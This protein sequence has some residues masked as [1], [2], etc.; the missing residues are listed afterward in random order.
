MKTLGAKADNLQKLSDA[1]FNVPKLYVV[2]GSKHL[3][4][5]R[6]IAEF[7]RWRAQNGVKAVA[8][9]SSS[10]QED[11]SENSFAGQF[12]TS[13]DVQTEEDFINALRKVAASKASK[14]YS[15]QDGIV[16]AIVQEFIEP[17]VAG[18][19]FSI[20]PATGNNEFVINAAS[21]RGTRVV[22]GKA[23]EQ[24]F[25]NRLDSDIS[26][27]GTTGSLTDDQIRELSD[28]TFKIESLFG[29]PQDIEWAIKDG[30]LYVL[31][32]RPITR[33]SHLRLWDS[34]NISESFPGIVL[35]LTYSI[36]KHGYMLVYKAQGYSAGLSWY[37]IEA[38]HRTFDAMIG[39]F[40]GRLYYN[41]L[42]W[43]KFI[44]IFPGSRANQQ[45]LDDQIATQ[46]QAIHQAPERQSLAFKSKFVSRALYRAVFFKK[47]LND[48]YVR[49]AKLENDIGHM[50][51]DGDSQILM[52]RYTHIEQTMVPHF[53][54]S[55][56]NDFFVMIYHGRLKKLLA[57]KES[58]NQANI[59]GA[60]NGVIS[61]EQATLLYELA[62]QFKKD[63]KAHD[64]LES[65]DYQALDNYLVGTELET[66]IKKYIEIF[67]HR[68][69]GDQKIEVKNPTLEPHGI[70]KLMKA[71]TQLD[72]S[73]VHERLSGTQAAA[74][75][76]EKSIES[77]LGLI[78]RLIYKFLLNRLKHHLRIREK[79]RLIRG[80]VYGYMRDLFPKVGEALVEEG[81]IK[82]AQDIFYL[83]IEEI[84]QLMQGALI[85]NDLQQRIENR[86]Q[87]YEEFS[88]IEMPERFITKNLP[89]V[90][91][92]EPIVK[93]K[94]AKSI[95]SIP[96]LI[97]SPGTV[98]GKAVVLNEPTIPNEP[99]DILIARHTDPGWT[100]LIA[101]AKGVVVEHGG[102][103][104]HA[105]IVT[106]ELGIPSIIGVENVTSLLDTGSRV[107]INTQ[108][109]SLE[110]LD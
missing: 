107:R 64:L 20:N 5:T 105:A 63:S 86:K 72:D 55:V 12:H 42:N 47:E 69:A 99:F 6:V 100:P 67:G 31:Q 24:Y 92:I 25:V 3:D 43:Y 97:S 60:I 50:P 23:A 79:N 98:E 94:A 83:E 17:D 2:P 96:G 108:S 36:A 73:E 57:T 66:G 52:Q 58:L 75:S 29:A 27:K 85:A 39:I 11:T 9:R 18:V 49:F 89:S 104:S 76:L 91:K 103:L 13:L 87:A 68:F 88:R 51:V 46:G 95:K 21:G 30:V 38:R 28:A 84:Y 93:T 106:R 82:K 32:A 101:L 54:R 15:Y 56:D 74:Q 41:L 1:G 4:E 90:E 33:I 59:I 81:A 102:M 53:G 77:N 61:S 19:I 45:F 110:I 35:P 16:N 48:F 109:S 26:H 65:A 44:S 22:E 10:T 37:E 8:V 70:Y 34:S 14:A 62:N 80:K 40:N 78:Q 7:N 71:Y